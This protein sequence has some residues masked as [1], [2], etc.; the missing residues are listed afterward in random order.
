MSRKNKEAMHLATDSR[1]LQRHKGQQHHGWICMDGRVPWPFLRLL[2]IWN[3]TRDLELKDVLLQSVLG[4]HCRDLF[5]NLRGLLSV[6][7]WLS[8]V[9]SCCGQLCQE[10]WL[11]KLGLAGKKQNF[12]S[13]G[14]GLGSFLISLPYLLAL[15]KAQE[16][17]RLSRMLLL[18]F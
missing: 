9:G 6:Q 7:G 12:P 10:C 11:P 18:L 5:L 3:L 4:R 1:H 13:K 16:F 17:T 15:R 8:T 2:D 14:K